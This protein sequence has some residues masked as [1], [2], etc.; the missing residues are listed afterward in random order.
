MNEV[1]GERGGV[2]WRGVATMAF[3][4]SSR[5]F[6]S[7][8][9]PLLTILDE[10]VASVAP[11]WTLQLLRRLVRFVVVVAAFTPYCWPLTRHGLSAAPGRMV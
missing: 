1:V 7:F 10:F 2:A 8:L 4:V 9:L 6:V 5:L 3:P 11:C